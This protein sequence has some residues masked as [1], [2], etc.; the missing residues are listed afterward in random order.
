MSKKQDLTG[1]TFNRLTVL[2]E[3]EN[4][5]GKIA[6]MCECS[7]GNKKAV[8]G[9]LLKNGNTKSCGCLKYENFARKRFVNLVGK[10]FGKLSVVEESPIRSNH[11]SIMW[12][13]L[14][15][16]GNTTYV[17]THSLKDGRTKSCGCYLTELARGDF[18]KKGNVYNLE[19]DY[20]IVYA[21]NTGNEF[22]FDVEDYDKIKHITWGEDTKGYLRGFY[23]N[24]MRSLHR[25]VLNQNVKNDTMVDHI[26][27]NIKDNRKENL[28]I[29]TNSGNIKN[30][31]LSVRNTSGVKGVS[32]DKEDLRWKANI[33]CNKKKYY[34][35][36]FVNKEDAIRIRELAELKLFG[37]YSRRYEEL[38]EKYKDVDLEKIK[39]T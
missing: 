30:S 39:I 33:Q 22:M 23:C 15:D 10:K 14:C 27:H 18:L 4:I 32:F 34:L 17:E 31:K 26:N 25:L 5:K 7:C 8:I 35:G 9:A 19:N 38:K 28:R 24:K 12:K 3:V 21:S 6:Y 1:Q 36:S 20:G 11:K 37:E 16:C 13:C 29:T 2:Y